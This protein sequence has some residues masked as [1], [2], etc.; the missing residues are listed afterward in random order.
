[1]LQPGHLKTN[2][3]DEAV[4]NTGRV[5]QFGSPKHGACWLNTGGAELFFLTLGHL[6][7]EK[8]KRKRLD[9]SENKRQVRE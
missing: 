7:S 4:R 6:M 2:S 5:P 1:M 9:S 8:R 3:R